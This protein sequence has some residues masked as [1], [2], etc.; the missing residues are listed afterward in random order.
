VKEKF[1]M[2][3]HRPAGL[4]LDVVAM[5]YLKFKIQLKF[6][7]NKTFSFVFVNFHKVCAKKYITLK[8]KIRDKQNC[9][10]K[11]EEDLSLVQCHF[12]VALTNEAASH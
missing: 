11:R 5:I 8:F 4:L 6:T 2:T 12:P 9:C 1:F 10:E 3:K 7:N